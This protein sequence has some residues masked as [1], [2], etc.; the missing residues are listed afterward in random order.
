MKRSS[1]V[2]GLTPPPEDLIGSE[3][4]VYA[5]GRSRE[6]AA[7]PRFGQPP[8]LRLVGI[9]AWGLFAAVGLKMAGWA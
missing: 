1:L 9:S 4:S 3:K 6:N 8:D 2:G 5:R 7:E